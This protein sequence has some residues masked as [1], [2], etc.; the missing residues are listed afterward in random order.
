[1][2]AFKREQAL[3]NEAVL[4]GPKR[5]R[6][7]TDAVCFVIFI[8]IGFLAVIL[9]VRVMIYGDANYIDRP[10]DYLGNLCGYPFTPLSQYPYLYYTFQGNNNLSF[11]S[12]C[13]QSCPSNNL[14]KFTQDGCFV[15][16]H[17]INCTDIPVYPSTVFLDGLCLPTDPVKRYKVS[18]TIQEY[19][20]QGVRNIGKELKFYWIAL[21]IGI[22]ILAL[23]C[24]IGLEMAPWCTLGI[25]TMGIFVLG[26]PLAYLV[27]KRGQA[28]S[29][30]AV[31]PSITVEPGLSAEL[32]SEGNYYRLFSQAFSLVL[33]VQFFYLLFCFRRIKMGVT[34][35]L[36]ASEFVSIYKE[37][38]LF[39]IAM[40]VIFGLYTWFFIAGIYASYSNGDKTPNPGYSFV[41]LNLT[42]RGV[43]SLLNPD[44]SS[45]RTLSSTTGSTRYAWGGH[46]TSWEEQPPSGSTIGRRKSSEV[47]S[48]SPDTGV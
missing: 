2:R 39:P 38:V 26:I 30:K 5:Q 11:T 32:V 14:A 43:Y 34:A 35:I 18:T 45:T 40:V 7:S 10:L 20:W 37:I 25:S 22:A 12:I 13:V 17:G 48:S 46:S 31:E 21:A 23:I 3:D 15:G 36:T 47:P 24:M 19:K 4:H 1:M 29:F 42:D 16:G 44:L 6:K 33:I 27:Y 28:S 41:L 9:A 8:F